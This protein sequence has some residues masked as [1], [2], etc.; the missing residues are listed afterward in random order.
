MTLTSFQF[1]PTG[2]TVRTTFRD[3][4]GEAWFIAA[5]ICAVLSVG[6]PQD[7]VRYLDDD[8]KGRCLVDT[9]YG[10]Q[11][12][13]IVNEPGLYSLILRSRKPEAKAFKRWVTHEVLPTIRKTGS[14]SVA[15]QVP[16]SLPEALRAYA[17]EVEAHAVT[18]ATLAE[19]QPKADAWNELVNADGDYSVREAAQILHRS[20]I[21][22]GQNRLFASLRDLGWIDGSGQP[23]QDQVD[24]GRLVRRTTSYTHPHTGEP[25]LSS[26]VRITA[27]GVETLRKR[28]GSSGQLTLV[29]GGA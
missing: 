27:K 1:P 24:T 26:Q 6:R 15:P 16:Q 28:L 21:P 17:D 2:H 11:E 5:D 7:S 25:V 12:M 9:P 10:K 14:Y 20:G 8:E 19:V 18:A 13:L 29:E 22:T 3:D 4:D 23:Y